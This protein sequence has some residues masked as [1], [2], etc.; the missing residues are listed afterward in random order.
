[1]L[2]SLPPS[3]AGG[4][5]ARPGTR[6]SMSKE[7]AAAVQSQVNLRVAGKPLGPVGCGTSVR[8]EGW[9]SDVGFRVSVLGLGWE[10]ALRSTPKGYLKELSSVVSDIPEALHNDS[11]P[12][13]IR[14][15][16][17]RDE[18]PKSRIAF[19]PKF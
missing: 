17:Q 13:E 10:F 9:G 11:L 19:R 7:H 18:L 14:S 12:L 3:L 4:P 15:E 16:T 5:G 2:T 6:A 8:A 1:M